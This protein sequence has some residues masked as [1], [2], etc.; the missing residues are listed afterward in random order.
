MELREVTAFD[1][2]LVFKVFLWHTLL[3]VRHIG[4]RFFVHQPCG[5]EIADLDV[6]ENLYVIV[7]LGY[8]GSRTI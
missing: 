1:F 6:R 7:T 4:P 2:L 8:A 5:S 3:R